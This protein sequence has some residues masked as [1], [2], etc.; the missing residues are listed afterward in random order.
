MRQRRDNV[1]PHFNS[2]C[3][4]SS[5]KAVVLRQI[6]PTLGTNHTIKNRAVFLDIHGLI[7]NIV[8]A[9]QLWIRGRNSFDTTPRQQQKSRGGIQDLDESRIDLRLST[10]DINIEIESLLVD[11]FRITFLD[12]FLHEFPIDV[13][14]GVDASDDI[15]VE[16]EETKHGLRG[17]P[18]VC[19]YEEE[20]GR[21]ALTE[22]L[23]EDVASALNEGFVPEDIETHLYFSLVAFQLE[24]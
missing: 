20:M 24:L 1:D 12:L 8:G 6:S 9:L 2:Q 7:D 19:V 17:K 22:S 14:F 4:A 10:D 21:L 13:F 23:G 15:L 3:L 18:D 5:H 16:I 11:G